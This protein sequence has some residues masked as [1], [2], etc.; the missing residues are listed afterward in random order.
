LLTK[1]Q[2]SRP[3]LDARARGCRCDECPLKDRAPVPPEIHPSK[4]VILGESPG[5]DEDYEGRPFVG[6]SGKLLNQTLAQF[7][8][9]RDQVHVT[10]TVLCLPRK[11]M[12]PDEWA[13][14]I[15]CCKPRLM[16]ELG[17]DRVVFAAGAR[18]TQSLLGHSKIMPWM[19]GPQVLPFGLVVIP[20]IHPAFALRSPAYLPVFKTLLARA[21]S[22]RL[23]WTWGEL[24]VVGPYA[25]KL[26]E[27]FGAEEI[28]VDIENSPG[29]GRIRCIG[30]GSRRLA[31]SVPLP[32]EGDATEEDIQVLRDLLASKIPKILQNGQHDRTELK[33]HGWV[34]NGPFFDTLL[35]HAVVAPRL[36]HDLGFMCAVEFAAPRW[37]TEFKVEGDDK[38]RQRSGRFDRAEIRDL[39]LYNCKDNIMQAKLA[40]RL[41]DRIKT[42]HNGPAL[43]AELEYLDELT[44]KMRERGVCIS[45]EA[46]IA[47]KGKLT[48][49][50][51]RIDGEFK[52]ILGIDKLSLYQLGKNGQ[53]KSLNRLFFDYFKA[54]PI[55]Y[56]EETGA[57]SLN[58]R[59][60]TYYI[61][62]YTEKGA[63]VI[64]QLARLILEYREQ[65]KLLGS[66]VDNLPVQ[67]EDGLLIVHPTWRTFGT[68]TGRWSATDPAIQTIPKTE[69]RDDGTIRKQGLRNLFCARPGM[70]LVEAD[71]KAL[72]LRVL[73]LLANDRKLI[74]WFAN[75]A[76]VHAI[77]AAEVFS[78]VWNKV[79]KDKQK[80]LRKLAK[81]VRFGKNYGGS[82]KTI[83]ANVI[84]K[85]PG[86][87]LEQ[88]SYV[89]KM[90][91]QLHPDTVA[92]KTRLLKEAT[93]NNF[94]EAPFSGRRQYYHDG[95]V[96]P[97]EVLNFPIQATAGDIANKAIRRTYESGIL[98]LAQVHDAIL[99][100]GPDGMDVARK[101]KAA[102]EFELELNGV[103]M[104][105]PVDISIGKNWGA[106][107]EVHL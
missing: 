10:N 73:A 100:E 72:E 93:N 62:L 94:V 7:G 74:E 15:E 92:W 17:N 75:N 3:T 60:L 52:A 78:A 19:G 70:D 85:A 28:S 80:D 32:P 50:L 79:S 102:M 21:C 38:G 89:F 55:E 101:L 12:R 104:F 71:Y 46:L 34:L 66:Y 30:V 42:V 20:S 82:D 56:S 6:A 2:R 59:A 14:A 81:G 18:A 8:L 77:T 98:P 11:K 44:L 86:I 103:R 35:A 106:M 47:H 23:G 76:D 53:H 29:S 91:D 4:L 61:R 41:R 43:L 33:H 105:F 65:A 64:A 63:P 26:H 96:V 16:E 5:Q 48:A 49:E 57:P 68:R 39:Q 67:E 107:R 95:H 58:N 51:A 90:I 1:L 37:K 87:K 36:P 83:W 97:T 45:R 99:A 27:L 40:L 88:I 13:A 24:I 69:Y 31:V 54:P 25:P 22:H 84:I 9:G